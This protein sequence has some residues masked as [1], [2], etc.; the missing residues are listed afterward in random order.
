MTQSLQLATAGAPGFHNHRISKVLVPLCRQT[1]RKLENN[2]GDP[3]SWH[4][5]AIGNKLCLYRIGCKKIIFNEN[6]RPCSSMFFNVLQCSSCSFMWIASARRTS[7]V[8][9]VQCSKGQSA[10]KRRPNELRVHPHSNCFQICQHEPHYKF[11]RDPPER[12]KHYIE[13]FE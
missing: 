9:E 7:S 12:A 13:D 2:A 8:T 6:I 10:A 1:A 4:S 11:S 5:S 3:W